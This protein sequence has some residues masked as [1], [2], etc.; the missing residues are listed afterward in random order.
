MAVTAGRAAAAGQPTAP[1]EAVGDPQ[2]ESGADRYFNNPLLTTVGGSFA[3]ISQGGRGQ[4]KQAQEGG[5]GGPPAL[6][7]RHRRLAGSTSA[8]REGKRVIAIGPSIQLEALRSE[9]GGGGPGTAWVRRRRTGTRQ[10][11]E[12]L[13]HVP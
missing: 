1:R 7:A 11:P 2:P 4:A 3:P 8:H 5:G 12:V 13:A 9:V 10:P 6:L